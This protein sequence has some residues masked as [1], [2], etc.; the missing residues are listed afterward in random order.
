MFECFRGTLECA[1]TSSRA[2]KALAVLGRM[3]T[4]KQ[5]TLH[6][7]SNHIA[8]AN[9]GM[10]IGGSGCRGSMV[11]EVSVVVAGQE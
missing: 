6:H 7:A 9:P 8:V 5:L 1:W 4:V 2:L 11:A 3:H 10:G